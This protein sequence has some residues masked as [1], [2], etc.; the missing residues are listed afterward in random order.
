MN[1]PS[2]TIYNSSSVHLFNELN[3][4][5]IWFKNQVQWVNCRIEFSSFIYYPFHCQPW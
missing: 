5:L 4:Q 1:Q 3:F 2:R